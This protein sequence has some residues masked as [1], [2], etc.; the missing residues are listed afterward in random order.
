VVISVV[1]ALLAL[2]IWFFFLAGSPLPSVRGDALP[3]EDSASDADSGRDLADLR[4]SGRPT[5]L[6]EARE[7]IRAEPSVVTTRVRTPR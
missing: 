4:R 1:A 2:E 6:R 7:R 3:V 5:R